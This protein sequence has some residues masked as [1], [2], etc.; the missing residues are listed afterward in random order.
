MLYNIRCGI[1]IVDVL[2]MVCSSKYC[3]FRRSFFRT[4]DTALLLFLSSGYFPAA[5]C[6]SFCNVV[7]FF[8][9]VYVRFFMY[10]LR[11]GWV[12][13]FFFVMSVS[14]DVFFVGLFYVFWCFLQINVL[15]YFLHLHRV[16]WTHGMWMSK[17]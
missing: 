9:F 17:R 2:A 12:L 13:T 11:A 15:C 14:S 4:I 6:N 16:C 5:T 8:C 7:F 3:Y 10:I 1:L